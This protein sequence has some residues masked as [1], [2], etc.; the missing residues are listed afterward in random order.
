MLKS[1]L[2]TFLLCWFLGGLGIHRFYVGKVGTGILWL[3]TGG[4]FG[5]GTFIDMVLILLNS[6]RD[7]MGNP[8]NNDIPTF[9]IVLLFLLWL[10]I[11]AILAFTGILFDISGAIMGA[12]F[13]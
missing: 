12:I 5:V 6:F 4:L 9:V 8:L 3:F 2:V 13:G 11:L 7:K 1:K 10:V